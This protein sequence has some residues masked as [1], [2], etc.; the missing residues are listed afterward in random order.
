MLVPFLKL[1][2]NKDQ[3]IRK[4][5]GFEWTAKGVEDYFL[6]QLSKI[7]LQNDNNLVTGL[8]FIIAIV[9][10]A[11]LLK[12]LFLFIAKYIINPIRNDVIRKIRGGLYSKILHLPIGYFSEERKGDII[13]RMSNDVSD[14]EQSIV[15]VMNLMF[16]API[17]VLFYLGIMFTISL[18][19]TLFLVV[20]LPIAGFLIGRISK[21]LKKQ[22]TQSQEYS[23]NILSMIDETL[24][25]LR[26]IKAFRAEEQQSE[27]FEQENNAL[28][29]MMN[30]IA[31]R[32]E[33]ASP[34]SE[35]LG[36]AV[37]GVVLWFGGNMVLGESEISEGAFIMFVLIFT[38]LLDPLKK[39]S[40]LFYNTAR[41]RAAFERIDKIL[42]A[43]N[44]IIDSPN[45]KSIQSFDRE[46]EFRNVSF[47]Y[48][49]QEVLKD[50]NLVIPKG[51]T[52]ALVGASGSGKSTLADL[53]PRFHEV[54]KG[55]ILIDGV[56]IKEYKLDDLRNLM[57][58]VSQ[59]AILFNSSIK[60]NI[61]LGQQ[62]KDDKRIEQSAQIAHADEFIDKKEAGYNTIIGDRG[63]KLS[64][65]EKQRLTIARA[66]Y[67]NPPI[68]ILDEA[69]SSLDTISEKM[70][71]DAIER[72]MENRTSLVIAHRLSTI[73]HAHEIIVLREGQVIERGKHE[74]LMA[75]NEAYSELVALQNIQ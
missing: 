41:G 36:V 68:L 56:N 29:H 72:I 15:A 8:L 42:G 9:V 21:R 33:L 34:L 24:G 18:K 39:L 60:E 73:K 1:L 37:L 44:P 65:G 3:L 30:R 11:T 5:P 35:F 20:L 13:S 46:I 66:M 61:T 27:S 22:S 62:F 26:I 40:Q 43:H 55:E 16:S 57:G 32:R 64:G 10:M 50:I 75:L 31:V 7:I 17:S 52:I 14:I 63:M 70:V 48:E 12:N 47:S 51:K 23:G 53:L 74:E 6:Y 49:D 28:Y 19:L 4:N 58:I 38:Q 69:T 54:A 45:A 71:Q 67:K 59:E 25:G 2:F